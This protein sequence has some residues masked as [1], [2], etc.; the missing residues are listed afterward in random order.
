MF[1]KIKLMKM[2]KIKYLLVVLVIAGLFSCNKLDRELETDLNQEQIAGSF[3]NVQNLLNGVYSE[4]RSGFLEI[5]N[6][7][8]MASATDEAEHTNEVNQVQQ[9][10][11]GSWNALSNPADVWG[12]YFRAVRRANFFLENAA[13]EKVNLDALC[14]KFKIDNSHRDFHGALVDTELLSKVYFELIGFS[15]Y[16]LPLETIIKENKSIKVNWNF[17]IVTP[18][19]EEKIQHNQ[20]IHSM[21]NSL[22]KNLV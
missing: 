18:S 20:M 5:N 12:S 14:K 8:M 21:N 22:W 11:Q 19:D 7:A 9:F 2:K 13:P 10:N 17:K 6:E 15:Q 4:S 16:R 1:V 3:V